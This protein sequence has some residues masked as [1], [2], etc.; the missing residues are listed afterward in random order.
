[1]PLPSPISIFSDLLHDEDVAKIFC[2]EVTLEHYLAFE[3][4]LAQSLAAS[5]L[6][7]SGSA[8]AVVKSAANFS[9]DVARITRSTA[10]D[11]VPIPEFVRQLKI[12]VGE[13]HASAV[14]FG[15]TSQDVMDTATVLSLQ[16]VTTLLAER[17]QMVVA[18]LSEIIEKD[19]A[20]P[21]MGRT[22]MQA[23]QPIT[24]AD[25]IR[26]WRDMIAQAASILELASDDLSVQLGGPVGTASAYGN[27]GDDIRNLVAKNLGMRG[28]SK[29]WHTQRGRIV[30]YA[31]ALSHLTGALA[32][33]GQDIALMTQ[34]GIEDISLRTG[35][36]SSAMPHKKN[37]VKAEVLVTLGRY[38]AVQLSGM[39][40][41]LIHEQERSGSAW[42]LEWMLMPS[43]CIAAGKALLTA[44]ELARDIVL[45]GEANQTLAPN[46]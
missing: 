33:M 7:D 1:M 32:K 13:K 45:P 30:S 27:N 39:H 42:T 17:S 36:G 14:H 37:P 23:A 44:E 4:A 26:T 6:V 29:C 28:S 25:R 18:S 38:N 12:A 19:G 40:H 41:A 16:R 2:T 21:L 31:D 10:A 9:P 5:G 43:M 46:P 22:R 24:M 20:I 15:A 34:Q 35:G 3:V 8:Q 11:G